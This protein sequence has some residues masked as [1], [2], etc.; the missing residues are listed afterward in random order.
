MWVLKYNT[1]ETNIF[2]KPSISSID[3]NTRVDNTI[4]LSPPSSSDFQLDTADT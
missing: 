4:K 1:L 2:P 3:K